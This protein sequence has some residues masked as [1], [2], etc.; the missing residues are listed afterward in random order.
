[1]LPCKHELKKLE[2]FLLKQNLF[3]FVFLTIF[4]IF[5]TTKTYA[6]QNGDI[7]AFVEDTKTDILIVVAGG[8]A[9][10]VLGLSTL[11]FVEEPKKHSKNILYGSSIGIIAGVAF[12][13]F[14]QANKSKEM[15]FNEQAVLRGT[16]E[17]GTLARAN[18]HFDNVTTFRANLPI[19][20]FG[21]SF[22][23]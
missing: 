14:N 21:Y 1:M 3:T 5:Y 19:P 10:A 22:S 8:L 20:Q 7:E 15:F 4:S 13:A 18:W 9:G 6:Q 17:F 16:S 12:V 23:Y 11:S 2:I